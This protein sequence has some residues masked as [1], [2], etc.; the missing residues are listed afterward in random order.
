MRALALAQFRTQYFVVGIVS[1]FLQTALEQNARNFSVL[2]I[3]QRQTQQTFESIRVI[4]RAH[5]NAENG[6][7][8]LR[9]HAHLFGELQQLSSF[10]RLSRLLCD[11]TL[12][13][14]RRKPF[15]R[16]GGVG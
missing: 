3:S 10:S 16:T 11:R 1:L 9:I 12:R 4:V 15:F 5:D 7:T 13:C 8:R 14:A 2:L 6:A